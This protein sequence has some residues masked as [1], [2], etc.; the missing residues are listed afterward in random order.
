MRG[1][2]SGWWGGKLLPHPLFIGAGANPQDS[3]VVLADGGDGLKLVEGDGVCVGCLF[4]A[5]DN[6]E[7]ESLLPGAAV[8]TVK[9]GAGHVKGSYGQA[10]AHLKHYIGFAYLFGLGG[11][12]VVINPIG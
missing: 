11:L 6:G 5:A 8:K 9:G 12:A 10:P 7:V 2:G 1:R 4:V 3:L